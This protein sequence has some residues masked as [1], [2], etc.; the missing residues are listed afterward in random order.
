MSTLDIK[1]FS[2]G[3]ITGFQFKILIHI[4]IPTHVVHTPQIRSVKFVGCI[5]IKI[6]T[7]YGYACHHPSK[8]GQQVAYV[9]VRV[10]VCVHIYNVYPYNTHT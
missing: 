4:Y 8:V 5:A 3:Q 2:Y 1:L 9:Y 10:S 6:L 7:H